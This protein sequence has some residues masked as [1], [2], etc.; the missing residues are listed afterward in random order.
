M[1]RSVSIVY[2]NLS[3]VDIEISTALHLGD[4]DD[5]PGDTTTKAETKLMGV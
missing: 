4:V 3:Y 2:M 5:E 1:R